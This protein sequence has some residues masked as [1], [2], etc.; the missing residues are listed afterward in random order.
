MKTST[1][2]LFIRST[3]L[4]VAFIS[5]TDDLFA[6][7]EKTNKL[8][9]FL[10]LVETTNDGIKLTAERGCAFKQLSF[11]F[12]KHEN[13]AIGPC[14]MTSLNEVQRCDSAAFL[15]VVNKTKEGLIFE[16]VNGTAWK[17][18]S[19]SC[20]DGKCYQYIDQNGMTNKYK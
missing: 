20:P 18:L 3:L 19:F 13:E 5:A 15:F 9:K 16:G 12:Y 2:N 8:A 14:G 17:K 4:I 7:D 1:I 11:S 10:I 6:Q